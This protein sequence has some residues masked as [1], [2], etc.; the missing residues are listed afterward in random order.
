MRARLATLNRERAGRPDDGTSVDAKATLAQLDDDIQ[1]LSERLER[2]IVVPAPAPP[3]TRVNVGASVELVD[4]NGETHTVTVVGE[5]E[6]DVAR[7]RISWCS[8]LGRAV[9][10]HEVGDE[11]IWQRPVGDLALEILAVRYVAAAGDGK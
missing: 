7:G 10:L 6:I 2:A 9:M 5:D 4:E 1:Y 11:V 3:W 8:P